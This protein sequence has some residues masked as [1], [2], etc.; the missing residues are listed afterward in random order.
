MSLE[1]VL[2][3]MKLQHSFYDNL[4]SHR[5]FTWSGQLQY[6]TGFFSSMPKNNLTENIEAQAQQPL[7]ATFTNMV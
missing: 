3:N 5:E 7:V 2:V 6:T 1:L 4:T